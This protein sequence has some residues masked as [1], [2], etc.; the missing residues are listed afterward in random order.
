M[1]YTFKFDFFLLFHAA[2]HQILSPFVDLVLLLSVNLLVVT[3]LAV[4]WILLSVFYELPL[5]EVVL[6]HSDFTD[7]FSAESLFQILMSEK[8]SILNLKKKNQKNKDWFQ[9]PQNI[10]R[11]ITIA[12]ISFFLFSAWCDY[13]SPYVLLVCTLSSWLQALLFLPSF[14]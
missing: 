1:L 14:Y 8:R 4:Q 6:F 3:G 9:F 2:F 12:F 10:W 13:D 5:L 7:W 11:L